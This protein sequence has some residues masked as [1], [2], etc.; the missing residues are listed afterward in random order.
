MKRAILINPKLMDPEKYSEQ[1]IK[2]S[3]EILM[4][5]DEIKK[6]PI[7]MKK[8]QLY[9]EQQKKKISSLADLKKAANESIKKAADAEME[10]A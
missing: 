9:W 8:V 4:E 6:D 1:F 3:A 5:A 10:N 7:L 2:E